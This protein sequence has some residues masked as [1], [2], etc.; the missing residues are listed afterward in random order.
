MTPNRRLEILCPA[1]TPAG[2]RAAVKAGADSVYLGFRNETNA[3]NFPGLNFDYAELRAGVEHAHNRGVKVYVAIN[4]YPR[5]GEPGPWHRAVDDAARAGADAVILADIGLLDYARRTHPELDRHLSVQASAASAAA[6]AFYR[7]RFAVT[8]VILPRVLTLD[9]VTRLTRAVEVETEVF[10][11]GGLCVMAEGRCTLSSY[12]TGE[13]PN[14]N[15]VCSP[16]SAV[17]YEED[18][19]GTLCSRLGG[20]TIN[21]FVPGEPAGY[22]TLCKGRFYARGEARYLFEDPTSLN[23]IAILPRLVDAGV[24]AVKI[25]GRQRG[26]AYVAQVVAAVRAAVDAVADGQPPDPAALAVLSEG[27]RETVGVYRKGWR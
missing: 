25:E 7:E 6:I 8:R 13:S 24:S 4:T 23:A 3:R 14:K 2:L 26:R 21:R 15:G 9:Q 17:R 18:G 22:P 1:G 19:D 11:F 5:A 10:V 20:F 12:V 16:A 27:G